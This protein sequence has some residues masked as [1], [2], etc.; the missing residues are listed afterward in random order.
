M[1]LSMYLL[2]RL[3]RSAKLRSYM[4]KIAVFILVVSVLPVLFG[5]SLWVIIVFPLYLF[6]FLAWPATFLIDFLYRPQVG[7]MHVEP[8]YTILFL[9]G[10][11]ETL[12]WDE[13]FAVAF[14]LSLFVNVLGA[15][16][17]YWVGKKH[18]I[19]LFG[20]KRW[21]TFWGLVGV[22]LIM[23]PFLSLFSAP[24]LVYAN[25]DVWGTLFGF[26]IILLETTFFSWLIKMRARIFSFD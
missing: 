20:S 18:R 10:Q 6:S 8:K 4:P 7:S 13:Y 9:T 24:D 2:Y 14:S 25:S 1:L 15:L 16:V 26:G 19:Q 12:S 17:G 21:K 5:V 23:A 11:F 22:T 3:A